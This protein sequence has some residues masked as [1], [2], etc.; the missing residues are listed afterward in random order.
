MDQ[1]QSVFP[2]MNSYFQVVNVYGFP[3]QTFI[4]FGQYERPHSVHRFDIQ[5]S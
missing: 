2:G 1:I 5:Q 3:I 4:F